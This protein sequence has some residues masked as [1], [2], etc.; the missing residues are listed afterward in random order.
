MAKF[1]YKEAIRIIK[2]NLG[3]TNEDVMEAKKDLEELDR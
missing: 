1:H 3:P 2:K